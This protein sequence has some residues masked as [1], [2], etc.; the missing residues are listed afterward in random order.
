[1]PVFKQNIFFLLLIGRSFIHILDKILLSEIYNAHM[2]S[3]SVEC[4]FLEVSLDERRYE[5]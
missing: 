5:F 2:F 4:L 3:Q 1:L